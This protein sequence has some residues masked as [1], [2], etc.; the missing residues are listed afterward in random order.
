MESGMIRNK[1]ESSRDQFGIHWF[2]LFQ[3]VKVSL[4]FLFL[5]VTED[6]AAADTFT[7]TAVAVTADAFTSTTAKVTSASLTAAA[8]AVKAGAAKAVAVAATVVTVA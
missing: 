5:C 3:D 6:E 7:S 8:G 4:L 1:L 2:L